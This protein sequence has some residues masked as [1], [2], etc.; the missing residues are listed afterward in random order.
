MKLFLFLVIAALAIPVCAQEPSHYDFGRMWTFENPPKAWFK[1]AYQFDA[2]DEWFNDARKA[3]L[4]FATWCSASFV[5]PDGLIMTNHHCSRGEVG[6]LQR[7]GDDF[8][9]R[10]FYAA[11]LRD[12]R[13]AEGLFVEQLLRVQDITADVKAIT[14]SAKSD[15]E[16]ISKTQMAFQQIQ[17][18]FAQKPGWE[19]LRLQIVS[20]YSGGKYSIYGYQRYDDIRLVFIPELD[21]GNF[22]GDPDNFTYPR[23]SLDFTFW[24]AYDE[25]GQPLDTRES[26]FKFDEE[27]VDPGDAVFVIGNPGSTERYRTVSQLEYDRDYRYPLQLE[28][29]HTANARLQEEYARNPSFEVQEQL[30][31]ISNQLKAFTGMHEGLN[32]PAL[33]GRKVAMEKKIRSMSGQ[34]YWDQIT[35]AYD[36]MGPQL[37]ELQLLSPDPE[38]RGSTITLLHVLYAYK[39][40]AEENEEAPDLEAMEEE[41]KSLSAELNTPEEQMLLATTLRQLKQFADPGDTYIDEILDGNTPEVAAKEI[42]D[43]TCFAK[44]QKL[45]KLLDKK[46]KKI[47]NEK[48]VLMDMADVLMP[49]HYA[50]VEYFQST[51]PARR[52]NEQKVVSEVFKVYGTNLPPDATFTLRISDGVVKTYEYSGTIAPYK[53]TYFGLYDRH[54]SHDLTN[55]WALPARWQN[56]SL[57]LLKSPVTFISTADI[58]GGNSGSPVINKEQELVGLAFDGNMESLPG[59]FIFDEEKNRTISVHAGGI[60]AALRYVYKADRLLTELLQK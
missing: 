15:E 58:T 16:T 47:A 41:I 59:N 57:D 45:E 26:Y 23:Y 29:L 34:N 19:D 44:P 38:N 48:D 12:E 5:S 42:L 53:T 6:A 13:R 1:E 50:A 33:F 27:G 11:T 14:S 56:P 39:T 32:N 9:Q 54:Y 20:Y 18:E 31:N 46:P 51:G 21:L 25:N 35:T 49:K 43:E 3:S 37:G 52:A 30:F 8:D 7:D 2:D 24:R 10:G 40:L 28:L 36:A 55:P 22:G 17:A 60:I 4:R